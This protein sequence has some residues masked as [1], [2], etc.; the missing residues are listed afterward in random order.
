[1]AGREKRRDLDEVDRSLIAA[2]R[3]DGRAANVEL[4]RTLGV[5]EKT[6][7]SRIA[8]LVDDF[9][10]RI[11]AELAEPVQQSRMVYLVHAEPGRRFEV[12]EFLAAQPEVDVVHLTTGSADVLVAASF[13][14]DA[15]ALRFLVQS[16][17]SHSGV[18]SAQSCHLIAEVGRDQPPAGGPPVDTEALAA[19]MLGSPRHADLG[20][21][22]EA[23]CDAA[24]AGLG[25][26]RVLVA[27]AEGERWV[28]TRRRGISDRYLDGLNRLIDGGVTDGVIKR[29]WQTRLHVLVADARTDPLFAAAHALVQAEGYVTILTLPMLYGESLVASVSLYYDTLYALDD[30]YIATAQGVADSFAV[31]MAR[32]LGRAPAVPSAP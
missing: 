6:V 21:L 22:A 18:R 1:V 10:L 23:V 27:T 29:V 31:A 11:T 28:V 25:A 17:E 26:D 8:R 7:R 12:A 32:M 4:A 2:L 3:H 9:G 19:V 14:D 5:S 30:A 16:V 20:E 13:P 24:T 15:A